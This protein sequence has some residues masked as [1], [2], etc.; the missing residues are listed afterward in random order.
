MALAL[1]QIEQLAR[2]HEGWANTEHGV[3]GEDIRRMLLPHVGH[4]G[5]PNAWGALIRRAIKK[6]LI[7]ATGEY[8][9][10]KEKRSHARRTMV[11]RFAGR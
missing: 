8:R 6:G 5:S 4:P 2:S 11:Y 7:V 1:L 9:H 10:M 3:I